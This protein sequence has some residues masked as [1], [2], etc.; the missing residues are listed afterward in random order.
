[1]SERYFATSYFPCSKIRVSTNKGNSFFQELISI[2][3]GGKYENG[4]VVAL[5]IAPIGP[6]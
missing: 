5:E 6:Q 3:K 2:E 1:M 4:R